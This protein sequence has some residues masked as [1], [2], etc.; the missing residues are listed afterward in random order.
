MLDSQPN[1]SYHYNSNQKIQTCKEKTNNCTKM[2]DLCIQ[3]FYQCLGRCEE[4]LTSQIDQMDE[5]EFY[6]GLIGNHSNYSDNFLSS[7]YGASK[8]DLQGIQLYL[9]FIGTGIDADMTRF[10][11]DIKAVLNRG[12]TFSIRVI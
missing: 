8:E 3:P 1:I 12:H 9:L 4:N 10:R 7:G 11:S 5:L 2:F 6:Q